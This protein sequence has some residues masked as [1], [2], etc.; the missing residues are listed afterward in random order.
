MK[1]ETNTEVAKEWNESDFRKRFDVEERIAVRI[2]E[3][4]TLVFDAEKEIKAKCGSHFV[5]TNYFISNQEGSYIFFAK[6]KVNKGLTKI[7]RTFLFDIWHKMAGLEDHKR[8]LQN[9]IK[10]FV[11][12]LKYF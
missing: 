12:S 10:N 3:C 6:F 9:E 8:Y 7:E 5:E 2:A 1:E 4:L 11:Q